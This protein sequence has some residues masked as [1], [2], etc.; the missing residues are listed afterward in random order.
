MT[1][2]RAELGEQIVKVADLL[3]TELLI[4]AADPVHAVAAARSLRALTDDALQQ[5]VG[6]ARERGTSWQRIGDALGT[7]RQAAF[8]RFGRPIDPRTGEVM[9]RELVPEADRLALELISA[10]SD[11]RW[12]DAR[13]TFGPAVAAALPPDALA[14]AWAQVIATVGELEGTDEPRVY[15]LAGVSVV[16]VVQHH[17]AADLLGRISYAADG[18][19]AGLWFLPVPPVPP[20]PQ[21]PAGPV[22]PSAGAATQA[23]TGS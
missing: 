18:T 15:P 23:R 16:E 20:V 13:A 6:A 8:Q 12:E 4:P 1:E 21:G 11:H 10:I 22:D 5:L 2:K 3:R 14:T 19:V 7:S 9:N 17:E